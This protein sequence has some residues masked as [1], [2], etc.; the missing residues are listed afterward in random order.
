MS[1]FGRQIGYSRYR[2]TLGAEN[3]IID[4]Y[5]ALIVKVNEHLFRLHKFTLYYKVVRQVCDYILLTLIGMFHQI[6]YMPS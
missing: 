2:A 6:A 1:K 5:L 4:C 3:S